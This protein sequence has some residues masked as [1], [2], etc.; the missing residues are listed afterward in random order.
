MPLP[1]GTQFG[2]QLSGMLHVTFRLDSVTHG[3]ELAFVSMRGEMQPASG[4]GVGVAGRAR[5]RDGE[6]ERW[7]STEGA[8]G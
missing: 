6:R 1:A 3:G 2:A 4:P 7:C 5:A 8:D